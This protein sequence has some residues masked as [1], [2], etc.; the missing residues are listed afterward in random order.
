V[1]EQAVMLDDGVT[2]A[3]ALD[4]PLVHKLLA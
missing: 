4:K 3:L 2:L 1:R